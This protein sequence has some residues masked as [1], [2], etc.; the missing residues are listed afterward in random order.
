MKQKHPKRSLKKSSK[1]TKGVRKS[2]KSKKKRKYLGKRAIPLHRIKN[3]YYRRASFSKRKKGLFN[4]VNKIC[5]LTG[6]NVLITIRSER[7]TLYSYASSDLGKYLRDLENKI[8]GEKEVPTV[9]KT[10]K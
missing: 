6:A 5:I 4:S 7:G 1:E 2:T 10:T 9:E 8:H 3:D